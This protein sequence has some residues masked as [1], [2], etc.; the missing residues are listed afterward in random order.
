MTKDRMEFSGRPDLSLTMRMKPLHVEFASQGAFGFAIGDVRLHLEEIP[1]YLRV[2]FLRR[3]VLAGSVGPFG[4]H[5]KPLEAEVRAIGLET[6]GVIGRE[7]TE[8]NLHGR[9]ACAAEVE[10]SREAFEDV[11][12]DL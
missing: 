12:E 9:G 8:I 5:L 7:E 2:P 3:R 4:V 1:V 6:R 10:I 11:A